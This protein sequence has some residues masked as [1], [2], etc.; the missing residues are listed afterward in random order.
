MLW[1]GI[2]D[3]GIAWVKDWIF[4]QDNWLFSL[5]PVHFLEFWL[6]GANPA[7]VII[8]GWV[9]F[10][11]SSITAGFIAR[12]LNAKYSFYIIPIILIFTGLYAHKYGL[13]SYSTS[14]NITNFFGLIS[15]L[16]L[17]KW[18][19]Y[20]EHYLLAIIL[21]L[22]IA[23]GLSDPWMLPSYT[24]PTSFVGVFMML[25]GTTNQE[26]TSGFLLVLATM[27]SVLLVKSLFF[28][29]LDFLPHMHFHVGNW[30]TIK[31][32]FFYLIKDLGRLLDTIPLHEPHTLL[33]SFISVAAV[34]ALY[35]AAIWSAA[36]Y[37]T[38]F[39]LQ[40]FFYLSFF[41]ISGTSFA[42]LISAEPATDMSARFVI[43]ILYLTTIYIAVTLEQHWAAIPIML[44]AAS[45]AVAILFMASGF[46]STYH[47]LSKPGFS[48]KTN[49]HQ[50]LMDF[51][52][53]ENLNYGYGP[54]WATAAN[55]VTALS[56]ASI[57]LRP[58]QFD[59]STGMPVFARRPETSK[60]WY[61]D[62]DVPYNQN[63]FF[64][65]VT[66]DVEECIV[67][68]TCKKGLILKYGPPNKL[69]YF[70]G[71]EILVWKKPLI[72]EGKSHY[73]NIRL[74]EEILFNT[75][76]PMPSEWTGW[77]KS[78][79]AGTWSNGDS[80]SL[81]LHLSDIPDQDLML[82]ID[83]QPFLTERRR[84]Q[85][86]SVL[87][88]TQLVSKIKY[89]RPSNNWTREIRIPR[90]LVTRNQ[91]KLSIVFH[92]DHVVSPAELG[93]NDDKR[94]MALNLHSILLKPYNHFLQH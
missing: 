41:S 8:T 39:L 17:L 83:G 73:I 28:G 74:N 40:A 69:L 20:K 87:I 2:S 35:A 14:H 45:I 78:E 64:V 3:H 19:K 62:E 85:G 33:Q 13:I 67:P 21:F 4:T 55:A 54:Y 84:T 24:L 52:S 77:S 36:R 59:K 30:E 53:K 82:V 38:S 18:C 86:I 70:K 23:G 66:Y 88:N 58:I 44:K 25:R 12:Q 68:T 1:Y 61:T 37:T 34:F 48:I 46:S 11:G 72:K 10:I 27:T 26:K 43:N 57:K 76:H 60:R 29:L 90:E 51:L 75:S 79:P 7:L 9:I 81:E 31:G 80:S 50:G 56:N 65:I 89:A 92:Y 32:N 47:L 94:R 15:T 91:G 49:R 42:L 22:N 63:T 6:F 5:V 16:A 93:L 71:Y